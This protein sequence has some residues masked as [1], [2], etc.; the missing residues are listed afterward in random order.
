LPRINDPHR[1]C[2]ANA[3]VYLIVNDQ[4]VIGTQSMGHVK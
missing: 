2:E 3:L 4:Q 1:Y